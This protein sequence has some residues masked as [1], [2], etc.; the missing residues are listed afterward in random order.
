MTNTKNLIHL[1]TSQRYFTGYALVFRGLYGAFLRMNALLLLAVISTVSSAEPSTLPI[2]GITGTDNREIK[3]TRHYPWS[4]IGRLNVTTGGFCTGT[5]IGPRRVLTAAHCLWNKRTN[6]WLPPC[7]LHFLA[8]YQRGE[9]GVHALV[10]KIQVVSGFKLKGRNPGQDWAVVTLD[11]D[12][13]KQTGVINIRQGP[14]GQQKNLIQAGYSRDHH[15]VLTVDRSCKITGSSKQGDYLGHNCDATFGDSGS[16]LL[17]NQNGVY[18]LIGVHVAVGGKGRSAQGIAVS[19]K[20]FVKWINSHPVKSPLGG[21]EACA[22]DY[23]VKVAAITQRWLT[24]LKNT[25]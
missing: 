6:R 23:S 15:H 5:V 8:G 18:E 19:N 20:A 24:V 17:M 13:S 1:R 7:S 14:I 4:A 25:M 9:Y 10:S 16:P 12:V 2:L 11:R 22:V 3:E 21:V